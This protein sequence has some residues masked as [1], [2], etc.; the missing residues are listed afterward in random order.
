MSEIEL[1]PLW[2]DQ[3]LAV[4]GSLNDDQLVDL[5][6]SEYIEACDKARL[7]MYGGYPAQWDEV[8]GCIVVA[9]ADW[10]SAPSLEIYERADIIS[11]MH[12]AIKGLVAEYQANQEE[13]EGETLTD[14]ILNTM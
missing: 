2:T 9:T 11:N 5:F 14:F 3:N 8:G 6:C 1:G 7:D 4:L 10:D 13:T 12:A